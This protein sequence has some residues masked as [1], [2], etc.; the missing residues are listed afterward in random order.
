MDFC[1]K[2]NE[3][4]F[5]FN[6]GVGDKI[7]AAAK[8]VKKIHSANDKEVKILQDAL[9]ELKEGMGSLT[10]RQKHI[11][12]ADQAKN[13]WRAVEAYRRA[14]IGD[15]KEDNKRIKLADDE[16]D[17]EVAQEKIWEA[18]KRSTTPTVFLPRIL[19]TTVAPL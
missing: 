17:E 6:A 16:V 1:R 8:K 7:E 11:R 4:Q 13:S 3:E 19:W 10:E 2:G 18:E 12:I 9:D 15:N 14:G 5:I